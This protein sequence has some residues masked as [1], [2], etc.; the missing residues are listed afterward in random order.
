MVKYYFKYVKFGPFYRPVIPITL[1]HEK[2]KIEYLALI[3]S[4]ADFNIFHGEIGELLG[5]KIRDL[6][7]ISFAGIKKTSDAEGFYTMI[8]IG[9]HNYFFTAPVIFSYDISSSGYGILGQQGFFNFF[10]V[11]MD[12]VS[13]SI[14]IK[15]I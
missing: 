12:Y 14:Q 2:K 9:V 11:K 1:K 15:K 4:G 6:Q 7:K 8:E 13:K 5:F 3:D 10:R